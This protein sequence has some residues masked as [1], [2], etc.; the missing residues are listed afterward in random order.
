MIL[1]RV[2]NPRALVHF[3]SQN[4]TETD[5]VKLLHFER[6]STLELKDGRNF[7]DSRRGSHHQTWNLSVH[8]G[9]L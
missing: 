9:V 2:T 8:S 6:P 3:S 5:F 7:T 1:E 4:L